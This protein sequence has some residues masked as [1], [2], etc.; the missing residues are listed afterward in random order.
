MEFKLSQFEC[1]VKLNSE[2][3]LA[4]S[5]LLVHVSYSPLINSIKWICFLIGKVAIQQ[6]LSGDLSELGRFVQWWGAGAKICRL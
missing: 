3:F 5:F 4:T 6:L 2:D 1:H